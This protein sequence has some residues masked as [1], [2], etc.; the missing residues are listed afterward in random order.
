MCRILRAIRLYIFL[1]QIMIFDFYP[2]TPKKIQFRRNSQ[3]SNSS[4]KYFSLLI[5][6]KPSCLLFQ[7]LNKVK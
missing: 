7:Y 5:F 3:I 1:L 2:Y 6:K 4:D